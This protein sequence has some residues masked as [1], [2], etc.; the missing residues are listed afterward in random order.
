MPQYQKN[1]VAMVL[2][3]IRDAVESLFDKLVGLVLVIVSFV[4]FALY[5]TVSLL[6]IIVPIV[7]GYAVFVV[8]LSDVDQIVKGIIF[9]AYSAGIFLFGGVL[10]FKGCEDIKKE[11]SEGLEM[12]EK[13]IA[14]IMSGTRRR[15][16]D[17]RSVD[18]KIYD[19]LM[20]IEAVRKKL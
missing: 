11:L 4:L 19:A 5:I 10:G 20:C 9:T 1:A 17:R 13:K 15:R 7:V 8:M 16:I 12:C 14:S 6:P 2:G 3:R 18:S